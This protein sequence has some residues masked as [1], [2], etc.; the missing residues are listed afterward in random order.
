MGMHLRNMMARVLEKERNNPEIKVTSDSPHKKKRKK[1]K[2]KKK[3]SS[4]MIL[5]HVT[6]FHEPIFTSPKP[7]MPSPKQSLQP[8]D[9][10]SSK[11]FN[12]LN[13]DTSLKNTVTNLETVCT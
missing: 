10:T 5:N 2:K 13:H 7:T 1:K 3:Q 6:S 8:D 9:T 11:Y 4:K 12:K